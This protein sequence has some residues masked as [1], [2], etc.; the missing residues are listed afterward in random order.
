[1]NWSFPFDV[2]YSVPFSLTNV[3]HSIS[4]TGFDPIAYEAFLRDADYISAQKQNR[5]ENYAKIL[6][7]YETAYSKG[8][9]LAGIK[10]ALL[11]SDECGTDV[12]KEKVYQI[13]SIAQKKGDLL[14]KT[15]I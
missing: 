7:L 3:S 6:A 14:V 4:N 11:Y 12:S 13:F 8:N 10:L 9:L 15:W 5:N 2:S 1:M